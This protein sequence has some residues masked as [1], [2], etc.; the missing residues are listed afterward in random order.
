VLIS[1]H[2]LPESGIGV[3]DVCNDVGGFSRM[4][5]KSPLPLR[6][7]IYIIMNT[8]QQSTSEIDPKTASEAEKEAAF[9]KELDLSVQNL[10]G[11]EQERRA[12]ATLKNLPGIG[13]VRIVQRGVWLKY[14]PR[15]VTKEKIL[16]ALREQGFDA[17]LFQD[18]ASGAAG[19]VE[20]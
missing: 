1:K 5:L 13:A 12:A 18:E 7:P 14:Q 9:Y 17:R 16:A 10:D 15:S 2:W 4:Y 11:D 3:G 20:F 19:R 6:T 8:T